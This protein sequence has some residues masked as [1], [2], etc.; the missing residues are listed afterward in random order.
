[1]YSYDR[2]SIALNN[3]NRLRHILDTF[4]APTL[5]TSTSK[6]PLIKTEGSG[7]NDYAVNV[8]KQELA[9]SGNISQLTSMSSSYDHHGSSSNIGGHRIN[10]KYLKP[11]AL[12]V[13]M[14]S[15]SGES[16]DS[17]L[18]SV[19][20]IKNEH[21]FDTSHG[22]IS[23]NSSDGEHH[24]DDHEADISGIAGGDDTDE[25]GGKGYDMLDMLATVANRNG[26]DLLPGNK[27]RDSIDEK[28]GK[29]AEKPPRQARF[30]FENPIPDQVYS[31]FLPFSF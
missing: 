18:D 22:N 14:R 7:S 20:G 16:V 6:S 15:A 2:I 26:K 19:V 3:L 28:G 27:S 5:T 10:S 11:D 21:P 13:N 12:V 17:H 4:V 25:K 30:S 24:D 29:S 23:S 9:A 1:V 8:L 31:F